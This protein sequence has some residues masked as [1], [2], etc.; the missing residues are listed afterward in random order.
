MTA[1]E[2][3]RSWRS[4]CIDRSLEIESLLERIKSDWIAATDRSTRDVIERALDALVVDLPQGLAASAC[5]YFSRDVAVRD[6]DSEAQPL[7]DTLRQEQQRLRELHH[8][9]PELREISNR[10]AELRRRKS[11]LE[12]Q[13]SK[14]ASPER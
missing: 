7:Q 1:L 14:L 13:L 3:S 6:G 4:E 11:D 5:D 2:L 8:R 12:D 10:I 9:N